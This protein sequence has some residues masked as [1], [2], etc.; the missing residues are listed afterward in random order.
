[1]QADEIWGFIQEKG[2][3]KRPEQANNETIGDA[4]TFV[5]VE[6]HARLVLNF[7][8]GRRNQGTADIFMERWPRGKLQSRDSA[9]LFTRSASTR[10]FR[11]PL[12]NRR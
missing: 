4:S 12:K 5:A 1:V 3:R 9:A 8:L 2:G 6:R 7:A 10:N 11:K